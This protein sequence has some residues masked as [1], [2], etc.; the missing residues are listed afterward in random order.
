MLKKPLKTV[1]SLAI[2]IFVLDQASKFFIAHTPSLK[3]AR[4]MPHLNF[5]LAHNKGAAFG[6]LSTAGGWQRSV[7]IIIALVVSGIFL[8]WSKRLSKKDRLET[9]A[10]G[11]VLGG[12][13][14]NLVDRIRFGYVVDFIDF[15]IGNWHW[16]TFNIADIAVCIGIALL[17]IL[18]FRS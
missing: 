6:L 2:V 14:G 8:L 5:H 3:Y 9:I 10:L 11:L 16:Y 4:I 7:L 13:W 12:A 1:L 18:N 15:Y 17:L